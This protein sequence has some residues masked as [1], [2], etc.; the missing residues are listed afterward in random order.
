[1]TA[2]VTFS[3]Q[4]S[5]AT[6]VSGGAQGGYSVFSANFNASYASKFSFSA[7]GTSEITARIAAVPPPLALLEAAKNPT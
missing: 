1:M 5:S 2:K 4:Q 6:S 3:V 7:S